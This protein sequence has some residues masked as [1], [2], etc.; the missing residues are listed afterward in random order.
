MVCVLF[1]IGGVLIMFNVVVLISMVILFG[2]LWNIMLG[3]FGVFVL[4]G[5][6]IGV[7]WVGGFV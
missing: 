6:Y 3:F 2:R 7:I 5:S 1:G 4:I